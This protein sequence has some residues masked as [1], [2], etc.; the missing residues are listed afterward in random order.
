MTA[1]HP[2]IS[3]QHRSR[4]NPWIVA[5]IV[6]A[7]ALVALGTWVLIDRGTTTTTQTVTVPRLLTASDVQRTFDGIDAAALA[8]DWAAVKAFYAPN[9]VL[10]DLNA[11]YSTAGSG[12]V[13]DYLL[14]ARNAGAIIRNY[15]EPILL[16]DGY[17]VT[18]QTVH[19]K[20]KPVSTEA[21]GANIVKFDAN[22]K[23]IHEWLTPLR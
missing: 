3:H 8:G 23:I 19:E 15:A 16:G 1:A 10:D 14:A 13:A 12:H 4:I 20:G 6:L 7:A 22:G 21:V 18:P 17:V 2:P 11:G 9:A 5:V